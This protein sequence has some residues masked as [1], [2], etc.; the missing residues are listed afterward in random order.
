MTHEVQITVTL[1]NPDQALQL[2]Q[3]CKRVSY[4]AAHELTE[5]HLSEDERRTRAYLM[6]GGLDA[7]ARAL[8][9]IGISPR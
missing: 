5:A 1:A 6:L 2:A 9:D 4:S 3:F 7:L 8:A